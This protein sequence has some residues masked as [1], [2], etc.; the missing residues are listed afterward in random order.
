MSFKDPSFQDRTASAADAK[1][2]A[3]DGL[4]AKPALDPEIVAQRAAV[5]E[6]KE[7][8]EREKRDAKRA[9]EDQVKRE[10]AEAKAAAIAA[11]LAAAEARK[12]KP[13]MTEEQRKAL[14]DAR[15]AARKGR[16]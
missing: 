13:I 1:K 7:T 8:A 10:K 14:R 6:A 2:K 12:P 15:Y 5:R 9:A 16:K 3:L 4:R 11:E